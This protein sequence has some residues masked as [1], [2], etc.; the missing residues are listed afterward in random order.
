MRRQ[1]EIP[2]SRKLVY[3]EPSP[4]VL[5]C[6]PASSPPKPDALTHSLAAL[7][8]LPRYETIREDIEAVID[9]N[10]LLERIDGVTRHVD[11][12]VENAGERVI[13]RR[14]GGDFFDSLKTMTAK[15]GAPYGIYHRLKVAEVTSG[16]PRWRLRF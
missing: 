16:S 3:V 13:R 2:V 6:D 15:W 10:R 7:I 8:G 14:I 12:D 1:S 9:R 5:D 4:E 11:R